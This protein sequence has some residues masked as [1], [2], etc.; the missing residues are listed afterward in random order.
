MQDLDRG[1]PHRSS[2]EGGALT[3]FFA[4][5][6]AIANH[7]TQDAHTFDPRDVDAW[8][9]LSTEDG[10]ELNSCV[11]SGAEALRTGTDTLRASI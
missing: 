8:V 1:Q 2:T 10:C 7:L 11:G 3:N 4:E 5:R 9:K 6:Q